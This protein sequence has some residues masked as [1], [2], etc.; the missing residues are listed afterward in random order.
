MRPLNRCRFL[1]PDRG[2]FS[3]PRNGVFFERPK[4][5]GAERDSDSRWREWPMVRGS[6]THSTRG[7]ES[8]SAW[9]SPVSDP[10][11]WV[12][13]PPLI[14]VQTATP[15]RGSENNP[16]SG[17]QEATSIQGSENG[18]RSGVRERRRFGGRKTTPDL[19]PGSDPK[20]GVGK[21]HPLWDQEAA[22]T[23][24]S[25]NEPRSGVRKRLRFGGRKRIP[26][27]FLTH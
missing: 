7:L 27:W 22:P 2:S 18:P 4:G 20:S 5:L 15:I 1:A 26:I 10:D 3:D 17:G 21:R 23:R 9:G 13:K 8:D 19:G 11:S 12:G 24:G 16:R 14:Q 6:D 25:G